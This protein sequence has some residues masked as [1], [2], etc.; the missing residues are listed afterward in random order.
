[1]APAF[2]IAL[3]EFAG[4]HGKPFLRARVLDEQQLCREQFA[5]TQMR[6]PDSVRREGAALE[7]AFINPSLNGDMR[8]PPSGDPVCARPCCNLP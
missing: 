6:F 8:A 5:E 3:A 7:P 1:M 2:D 4:D